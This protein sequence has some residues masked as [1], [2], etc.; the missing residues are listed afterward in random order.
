VNPDTLNI[1]A[2]W[3]PTPEPLSKAAGMHRWIWDLR[4]A[5]PPPRTGSG[6]GGGGGD[7]F[8]NQTPMVLPGTYT[9]KL[10][11]AG[12]SYTQPLVLKMDPRAR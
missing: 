12:V 6:A 3:R 10:T 11:V 7:E 8:G 5:P 9:V 4:P 1:P 2:F